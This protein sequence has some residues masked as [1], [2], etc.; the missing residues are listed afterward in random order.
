LRR[1]DLPTLESNFG[2]YGVR[3]DELARGVDASK[4]VPDRPTQFISAE[5]TFERDVPLNGNGADDSQTRRVD[6]GRIAQGKPDCE[7]CGAEIE[8]GGI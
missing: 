1:L 8:D 5:D 6:L 4:V 7:N 3:L 2:R